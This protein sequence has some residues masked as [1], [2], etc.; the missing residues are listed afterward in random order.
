MKNHLLLFM[1]AGVLALS[2]CNKAKN[3]TTTET[4]LSEKKGGKFF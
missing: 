1:A 2:G 3:K 4:V